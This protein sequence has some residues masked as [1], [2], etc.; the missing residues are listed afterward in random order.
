MVRIMKGQ[1]DSQCRAFQLAID[2][3]GRQWNALILTVLM[4]GPLRFNALKKQAQGPGDKVLS[5]RLRDL[6][7]R[8]LL[9]RRLEP[10]PPIQVI[11]QLTSK[12][13]AFGKV[14]KAIERWGRTLAK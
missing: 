2:V 7:A 3:L 1:I 12:G 14:A 13:R 10:G 8:G 9:S 11:Y 6:E 5:A 4:E